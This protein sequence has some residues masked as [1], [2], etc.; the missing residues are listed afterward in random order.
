MNTK[1]YLIG[2]FCVLFMLGSW[3]YFLT[4]KYYNPTCE[5]PAKAVAVVVV[6]TND[7]VVSKSAVTNKA[8]VIPAKPA[9]SPKKAVKKVAVASEYDL[10]GVDGNRLFDY[11]ETAENPWGDPEMVG[12]KN[13]RHRAYGLLQIR[14]PCL[15]DVCRIARKDMLRKYGR[16]LTIADMKDRNKARWVARVYLHYYGKEYTR[17]TGKRATMKIYAMIHNGGPRGWHP[18]NVDAKRYWAKVVRVNC[19]EVS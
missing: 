9:V 14:Q 4:D 7:V 11:L 12:D 13:L 10:P 3:T 5:V 1:N 2:L 6:P 17:I 15:T 19:L 16:M 8:K 18:R